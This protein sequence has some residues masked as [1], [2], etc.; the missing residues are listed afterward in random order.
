MKGESLTD[1]LDSSKY[2]TTTTSR[3]QYITY[4]MFDF[5]FTSVNCNL[6]KQLI[7]FR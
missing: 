6:S 4:M 5:Y 2:S 7:L 1:S 3:G